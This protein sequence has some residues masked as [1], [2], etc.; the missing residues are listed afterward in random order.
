MRSAESWADFFWS[1]EMVASRFDIEN[2]QNDALKAAA[3]IKL[4]IPNFSNK[5]EA[6]I[7]NRALNDFE[8]AI[9]ALQSKP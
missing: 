1:N 7:Y 3:N 8:R 2:I 9:L 6:N 4:E 5:H